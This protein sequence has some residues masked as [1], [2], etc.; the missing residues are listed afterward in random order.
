MNRPA[1]MQDMGWLLTNFA[2]SVAGIAHVV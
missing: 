1:A 2:D